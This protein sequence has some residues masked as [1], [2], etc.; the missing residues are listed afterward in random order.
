M[1]RASS[2]RRRVAL[3]VGVALS[4]A[5]G[6]LF[7]ILDLAVDG[8]LY[9]RFDDG[10]ASRA[11]AIAAYLGA[12]VDGAPPIERWMPEF[13]EAGHT[14]FFQAWDGRGDVVARSGSA[15]SSDLPRPPAIGDAAYL[16]FDLPLPDGHRGRAV[17]RRYPL[18]DGGVL[19]LVVAEER[20]QIDTLEQRLHLMLAAAISLALALALWLATRG[21]NLGLR[22]LDRLADRIAGLGFAASPRERLDNGSLPR[23]LAPVARRFDEVI[24]AL[25]ANLA[26]ERRFAQDLAHELRTPVAEL[27]AI[28]ETS[29]LL[30]EPARQRQALEELSRLAAE[31]EQ[32]VEALLALARHDAGLVVAQPEPLDLADLVRTSHRRQAAR[33]APRELRV[34]PPPAGQEAWVLADA[35]I[36]T[37]LVA[38]LVGNAIDHA[39]AGSAVAIRIDR[40]PTRLVVENDAPRLTAEDLPQLGR[41]FFR[42]GG[43][44][45]GAGPHAGLGLALARALAQVQALSLSFALAD[46]R[47]RVELAGWTDL[48]AAP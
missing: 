43:G 48:D 14:D 47:L 2:L 13:R 32:T 33:L 37:R 11:N 12:R 34:Q 45:D 20:E 41:R 30:P 46:G 40:H 28:T 1:P 29:L 9:R 38:I 22:P 24:D 8:E 21:A 42:A 10:L 36:S 18:G 39:P 3:G 6:G 16:Y 5:L 35:S 23:E 44:D 15:Q 7:L 25:L 17:A 26:R 19:D 4:L 31:M 27:R